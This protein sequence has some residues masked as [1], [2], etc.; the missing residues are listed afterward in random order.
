MI[1]TS[2][3][4]LT[5]TGQVTQTIYRNGFIVKVTCLWSVFIFTIREL[6]KL[7]ARMLTS[8][9]SVTPRAVNQQAEGLG[10]V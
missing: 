10:R 2:K 6:A 3:G 7:Y 9:V 8:S 4:D 1:F 5:G